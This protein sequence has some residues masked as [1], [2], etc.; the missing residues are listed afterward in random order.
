MSAVHVTSGVFAGN[1]GINRGWRRGE[2]D[3]CPF[4]EKY[5]KLHT[6][7][8]LWDSVC[9]VVSIFYSNRKILDRVIQLK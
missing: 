4:C 1:R 9:I 5:N 3:I 7:E 6:I 2:G 8:L